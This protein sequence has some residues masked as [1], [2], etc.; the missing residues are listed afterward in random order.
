MEAKTDSG[1]PTAP[2]SEA[3]AAVISVV[4][5]DVLL[6]EILLRLSFPTTLVPA[7][8]ISKRW[9]RHASDPAFLRGPATHLRSSASTLGLV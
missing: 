7:A 8:L 6:R 5:D 3:S 4:L 1:E 9:F 2:P